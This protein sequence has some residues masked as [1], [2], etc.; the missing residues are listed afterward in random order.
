MENDGKKG[1]GVREGKEKEVKSNGGI[2]GKDHRQH[3]R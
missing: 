1:N 3:E 2:L